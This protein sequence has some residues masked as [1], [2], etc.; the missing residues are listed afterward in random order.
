VVVNYNG[1]AV[2]PQTLR[3]LAC[4]LLP[5]D[6]VIVVDDAS[7]DG[8]EAMVQQ[9]LPQARVLRQPV[10]SGPAAARNRAFHQA[11]RR[12]VLFLDNDVRIAPGCLEELMAAL[13]AYAKAA[14]AMPRVLRL[15]GHETV[16]Y[17][18]AAAHLLGLMI[19]ENAGRPTSGLGE[20]TREIG[21]IV[22]AC[23]LIDRDRLAYADPFDGAFGIYLEDHDLGLRAR[24]A[25][26]TLLAV[27]RGICFHG[28]G[29]P[30]L[31]LRLMGRYAPERVIAVIRNRWRILLKDYSVWTLIV[32]CPVM[33]AFELFQFVGAAKKGWLAYWWRAARETAYALPAILAERRR[34]QAMRQVSDRDL[35]VSGPLPFTSLLVHGALERAG[36]HVLETFVAAYWRLC[37]GLL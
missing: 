1:A 14:A 36:R 24:L 8:S 20:E 28:E 21:S 26:A 31:S 7:A 6:E 16:Q 15:D 32:L 33:A 5:A 17:D 10:R 11:T 13:A 9:E 4:A 3:A 35:F 27:P 2:L 23:L 29:T 34:V 18:G 30:G 22:S 25:G 37:R 19:L 12:H